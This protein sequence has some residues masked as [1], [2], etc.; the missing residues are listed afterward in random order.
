[1][2]EEC[3]DKNGVA[4]FMPNVSCQRLCN[5]RADG[6]CAVERSPGT[7]TESGGHCGYSWWRI[8]CF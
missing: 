6:S 4:G 1:V 2:W 7:E 5:K 8:T 3:S